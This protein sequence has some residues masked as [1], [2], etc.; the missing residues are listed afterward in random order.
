MVG[1]GVAEATVLDGV[2]VGEIRVRGATV[3][4]GYWRNPEATASAITWL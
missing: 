3:T 1:D 4:P 2:A